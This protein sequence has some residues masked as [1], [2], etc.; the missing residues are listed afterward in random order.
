MSFKH[1]FNLNFTKFTGFIKASALS[2]IFISFPL[3]ATVATMNI[4]NADESPLY[5]VAVESDKKHI[6]NTKIIPWSIFKGLVCMLPIP[7]WY[8]I[9]LTYIGSSF[10]TGNEAMHFVPFSKYHRIDGCK[11]NPKTGLIG[12]AHDK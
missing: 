5:K 10:Y 9:S 6:V 12:V 4:I 1:I 2:N 7:F 11:Y 3:A 8:I